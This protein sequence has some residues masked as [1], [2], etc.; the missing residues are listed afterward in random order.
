MNASKFSV[1][2]GHAIRTNVELALQALLVYLSCKL[3]WRSTKARVRVP[4][5]VAQR[6]VSSPFVRRLVTCVKRNFNCMLMF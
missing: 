6:V 1:N 5:P 2:L 3:V 4:C